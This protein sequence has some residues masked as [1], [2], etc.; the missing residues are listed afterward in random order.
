MCLYL[1]VWLAI[2]VA[3]VSLILP[4]IALVLSKVL[5]MHTIKCLLT[6]IYFRVFANT[7]SNFLKPWEKLLGV[8]F[9]LVEM[10]MVMSWRYFVVSDDEDYEDDDDEDDDDQE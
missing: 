6:Q 8:A 4:L 9:S 10:R 1:V 7:I 5:Q 3:A 2:A